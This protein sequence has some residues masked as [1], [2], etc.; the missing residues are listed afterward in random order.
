MVTSQVSTSAANTEKTMTIARGNKKRIFIRTLTVTTRGGDVAADTNIIINDNGT[1]VWGAVL[2]SGK[3]FGGHFDFGK[4]LPIRNG[5]CTIV[6][7]DAGA[8]VITE[9][10]A[11]YE[12][13]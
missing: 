9:T 1:K 13:I 12:V 6:V 11:I 5:A 8:N 4:G 3:V 2:R 7:D 10:S